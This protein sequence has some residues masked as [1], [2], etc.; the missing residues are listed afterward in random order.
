[1]C[2]RLSL[3]VGADLVQWRVY[4]GQNMSSDVHSG[5]LLRG[6]CALGLN[7]KRASGMQ[8]SF[9]LPGKRNKLIT[10][11]LGVQVPLGAPDFSLVTSSGAGLVQ[12]ISVAPFK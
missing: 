9:R 12:R 3:G 5:K 6:S 2:L 8:K 7:A 1:M 4:C 11:W 10:D